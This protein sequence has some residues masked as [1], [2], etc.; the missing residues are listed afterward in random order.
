MG[1]PYEGFYK[2]GCAAGNTDHD[3]EYPEGCPEEPETLWY[4]TAERA[5]EAWNILALPEE[6]G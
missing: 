5:A 1:T 2:V 6:P 3:D 4:P